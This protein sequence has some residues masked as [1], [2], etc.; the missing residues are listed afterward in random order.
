MIKTNYIN[1][2]LILFSLFTFGC[3]NKKDIFFYIENE[4][5][6]D[7]QVVLDVFVDNELY[8]IDTVHS[9]RVSPNYSVHK[10][11]VSKGQHEVKVTCRI[12]DLIEKDT[13][14]VDKNA[15]V[16]ITYKYRLWDETARKFQKQEFELLYPPKDFPDKKFVFDSIAIPRSIEIYST[17]VKPLL[18]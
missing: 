2:G 10:L 14:V 18:Q 5:R 11:T 6:I 8:M 13:F 1:Y 9:S 7:S 4:S 17:D 16:F 12:N 3:E 15:Y